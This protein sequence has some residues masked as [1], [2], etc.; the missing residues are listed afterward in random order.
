MK[1]EAVDL[2]AIGEEHIEGFVW[3]EEM[4]GGMLWLN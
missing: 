2:K 4:E 3:R 1:K